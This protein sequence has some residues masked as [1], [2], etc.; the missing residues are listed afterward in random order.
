MQFIFKKRNHNST[1][2]YI[3]YCVPWSQVAFAH[4]KF[5]AFRSREFV[6]NM[7]DH[8]ESRLI[9]ADLDKQHFSQVDSCFPVIMA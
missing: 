9:S 4:P 3:K 2:K 5:Q 1:A 6:L 8:Q 7:I